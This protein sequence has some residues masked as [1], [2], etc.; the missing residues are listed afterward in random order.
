MTKQPLSQALFSE[1]DEQL[2]DDTSQKYLVWY[3]DEIA[4][5]CR[6]SINGKCQPAGQGVISSSQRAEPL[7][8]AGASQSGHTWSVGL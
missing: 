8:P 2:G 5:D 7:L 1:T 6:Q 4:P 3:G